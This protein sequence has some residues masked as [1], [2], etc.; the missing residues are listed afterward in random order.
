MWKDWLALHAITHLQ[1]T[2][3]LLRVMVEQKLLQSL[4]CQWIISG[5]EALPQQTVQHFFQTSHARLVNAY[6]PTECTV[7]VLVSEI[8]CDTNHERVYLGGPIPNVQ[9]YVL[10]DQQQLLPLGVPG[11]LWVAGLGLARGYLNDKVLTEERFIPAP[12]HD[13]R[14][15]YRSGDRVRRIDNDHFEFL[16]R[17]DHQVKI[18]GFR[19]ELGEI[20]ALLQQHPFVEQALVLLHEAP[21]SPPKM[22][23][24]Y[25]QST[26]IDPLELKHYLS[27]RLPTYL[28]PHEFVALDQFPLNSNGKLDPKALPDYQSLHS[29]KQEEPMTETEKLILDVWKKVLGRNDIGIHDDFF[30]VGGDSLLAIE[31]V[32]DLE[33]L[34]TKALSTEIIFDYSTIK[35]LSNWILHGDGKIRSQNNRLHDDLELPVVLFTQQS[36][37]FHITENILLTG[38]TG[39][40]GVFLLEELLRTTEAKIYCLIHKKD[41]QIPENRLRDALLK[42]SVAISLP[43]PRVMVLSGDISQPNLGLS[44][45][46]FEHLAIEIDTIYHAAAEISFVSSYEKIRETNVYGTKE[47][48]KLMWLK[49]NKAFHF[50]SSLSIFDSPEFFGKTVFE[51]SSEGDFEKLYTGY[52][53]SKWVCEHLIEAAKDRG[54]IIVV[55]RLGRVGGHSIHHQWNLNDIEYSL[56]LSCFYSETIPDL[57]LQ[58]DFAPIDF[59]TKAIVTLSKNPQHYGKYFHIMNPCPV[60]WDEV[61]VYFQKNN[62][63]FKKAFLWPVGKCS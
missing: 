59:V 28:L 9:T 39:F 41:Q 58:L 12:F 46:E 17:K 53:K 3:S 57:Q 60:D 13:N 21:G 25:S 22:I 16:G 26:P 8:L 43:H 42:Y 37:R 44:E 62:H 33:L 47:L 20:E 35:D 31:T 6:G 50:I 24:Y 38:V 1:A 32:L 5:G 30:E 36:P 27:L 11:E 23:A 14:R 34:F 19:V 40:V 2:P 54:A 18:R 56:L 61:F 63:H 15:L 10:D 49:K 48:L 51:K 45:F 7:D 55:Y 4:P 29:M 52:F